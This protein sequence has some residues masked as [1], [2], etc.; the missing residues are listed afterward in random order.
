MVLSS[1]TGETVATF[2]AGPPGFFPQPLVVSGR[3]II[4]GRGILYCFAVP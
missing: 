1:Q 3:V 4:A 2:P